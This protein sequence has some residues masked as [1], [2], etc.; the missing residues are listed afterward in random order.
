MGRRLAEARQ[1]AGAGAGAKTGPTRTQLL[2]MTSAQ[3]NAALVAAGWGPQKISQV[4]H[5]LEARKAPPR[6]GR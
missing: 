5:D 4:L 2:A 1:Q 3:R 6:T